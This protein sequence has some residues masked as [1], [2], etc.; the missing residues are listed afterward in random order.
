MGN[1]KQED[2]PEE[3]K[4]FE[5]LVDMDEVLFGLNLYAHNRG[6][7]DYSILCLAVVDLWLKKIGTLDNPSE[8][9]NIAITSVLKG[10]RLLRGA[11]LQIFK[12]YLPESEILFRS[13]FET[14]LVL[15]YILDDPTDSRVKKYLTFD[16]KKIWDFRLLCEDLLGDGSY[17]IYA[18]FSQ[19]PHPYNVG[20]AKLVHHD[21]LQSSSMHDYDKA[22]QLLVQIGNAAV[23]LCEQSSKIFEDN[24]E[25]N[26]KHQEICDTEISKNNIKIVQD[27]IDKGDKMLL[28]S[29]SK[30][31]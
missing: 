19:Y 10:R 6:E 9:Q 8:K 22:G 7:I 1:E 5:R 18:N 29:L 30:I 4:Y 14:Q 26:K 31:R 28:K 16:K 15:S 23:G 11:Q 3:L 2:W 17:E 21:K 24:P 20:R 27:K 13:I 12:G 25:W